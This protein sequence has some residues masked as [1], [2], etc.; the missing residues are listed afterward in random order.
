MKNLMI[1]ILTT[2]LSMPILCS[3]QNKHKPDLKPYSQFAP[4][5][6]AYLKTNFGSGGFNFYGGRPVKHLLDDIDLEIKIIEIV[7]SGS[8]DNKR[9]WQLNFFV[10]SPDQLRF[11]DGY[12]CNSPVT[13]TLKHQYQ[14]KDGEIYDLLTEGHTDRYWKPFDEK[15][16][17]LVEPLI[18]GLVNYHDDN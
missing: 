11:S 10:E 5:T 4:D 15:M 6:V 2:A 18:I 9:A 13:V 12:I 16:R 14:K 1:I 3:A 17:K 7:I 8:S